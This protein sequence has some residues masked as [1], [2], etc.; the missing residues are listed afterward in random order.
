MSKNKPS[1]KEKEAITSTSMTA[2]GADSF[3]DQFFLSPAIKQEI[4]SQGMVYRWIN[5]KIFQDNHGFDRRQWQPFK[6]KLASSSGSLGNSDSEGYIRRGDLILA[7]QSLETA[8][9]RRA[10]LDRRKQALNSAVQNKEA[11]RELKRTLSDAGIKAK[12]LEGYDE[13]GDD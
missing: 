10:I 1:L 3:D 11:A 6:S 7:V 5:A 4:E 9:R 13:N 8:T 2:S 12:V